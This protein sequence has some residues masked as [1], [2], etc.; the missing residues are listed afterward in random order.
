MKVK[1]GNRVTSL[2][3]NVVIAHMANFLATRSIVLR[4]DKDFKSAFIR[5][6]SLAT[7]FLRQNKNFVFSIGKDDWLEKFLEFEAQQQALLLQEIYF[8]FSDETFW[9]ISLNDIVNLKILYDGLNSNQKTELLSAP[10]KLAEWAQEKLSWDQVKDFAIIRDVTGKNDVY[11]QEWPS[12][13]KKII[14]YNFESEKN[15]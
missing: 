9:S 8:Q 1:I 12:V 10:I 14:V 7:E 4:K 5:Y 11:N 2:P 3:K 15:D 13:S 6:K